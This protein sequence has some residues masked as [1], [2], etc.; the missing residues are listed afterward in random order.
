MLDS[1]GSSVRDALAIADLIHDKTLD[2][3]VLSGALCA[4]SCPIIFAAGTARIASPDAAIGV[5]QIY[6]ATLSANPQDA[7]RTAGLAMSDAQSI[8]AT[9]I[10]GLTRSG[11]DPALWLH[12]LVTPPE[13]LYYLSAAE[14]NRL[15]LVTEFVQK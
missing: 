4:S 14:M 6:A 8:T 15:N 10:T 12:A 11:V 9:I 3:Q 1:P 7:L 2:T 5:H 13:Q